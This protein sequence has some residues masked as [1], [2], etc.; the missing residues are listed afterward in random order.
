M[1]RSTVG[2]IAV[3]VVSFGDVR[4]A[5][6]QPGPAARPGRFEVSAGALWVGHQALGS[7]DAN[8]TTP[9]GGRLRIF[10][11]S[12]DLTAGAGVEG[13]VG[14]RLTRSL[15]AEVEGSYGAP[16]LNIA[17]SNDVENA[18]PVTAIER[19]RQLTAG[20]AV[21]WYMPFRRGPR[22]MPFVTAGGGHL[23]QIHEG[24]TLI[25]TGQYYQVGGGLKFLLVSRRRGLVSAVGARLDLRAVMRIKGVA[26]DERG[27]AAPAV[28][29]SA[30]VRF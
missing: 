3:C 17:I 16:R 5:A 23:R 10:S 9:S 6:A 29:A 15:D 13:R 28:G 22:L 27:H 12:S 30:F 21:V 24:R 25:E 1:N 7:T 18:P 2:A 26:F 14:V 19:M 8:A 4:H 20:A 11:A